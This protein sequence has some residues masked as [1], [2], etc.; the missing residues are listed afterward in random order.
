MPEEPVLVVGAGVAGLAAAV[1]LA[2]RGRA[3]TV[4]ER[5]PTPGGKL[6]EVE[7]DGRR[8]DA[9][10]TVLTLRGIFDELFDVAG[11]RL[12]EHLSLTPVSVLAR[13]AWG[14]DAQL[15]LHADPVRSADA[16][17]AFAG[18]AEARRYTEFLARSRRVYETLEPSFIRAP[19]P[20][21]A[22]LVR[23]AG[24]RNLGALAA[25]SPFRSLWSALGDHFHDP[26]LR[27][28]FGRYATYLGSSPYQA[29]A[30]LMLLAHVEQA[31]V[32]LVD[33]GMHRIAQVLA[34]LATKLGATI[35]YES[36]AR[37]I[38]IVR[39]E[40]RGVILAS[41]ERVGASAV[42]VNADASAL[43]DGSLGVIAAHA[44]PV[45][46]VGE[47]SLSA[48]TW[49]IVAD[50]EG[51]AL[52][53]HTVFFSSDYAR[54]FDDIFRRDSLPNEPTVYICA[55]DRDDVGRRSGTGP[56]RLLCL[57]NA[58]PTGDRR[59]FTSAEIESCEQR[60]F[61]LL[62]RSGL[63]IRRTPGRTA[64]TTPADF[65]RLFPG[66]GGSLYG[67]ASHGWQASFR[68]PGVRTRTRG[69]YLAGGS[70][71]PGPGVPMAA[72]CGRLAAGALIAD[73]ASTRR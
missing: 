30:T 38:E 51:F 70:I 43:G 48:L 54:E 63:R 2:A 3:V 45:V 49:N 66:S 60:T 4:L 40:T 73:S 61:T 7:I 46:P 68:R 21:I 20:S 1:E 69:L 8:L 9:G 23:H 29:P 33:G 18:A 58:P 28:L 27:Q 42:I 6:R 72:L 25:V 55:Q 44:A 47:R 59:P 10:P 56:E 71:H 57:V 22:R 12:E 67:R 64:I 39:G 31:G 52:S 62:E 13:H 32:W 37:T 17:G 35:R 41:G 36:E 26:R 11:T 34:Q 16:I 5:G 14:P 19:A 50:A 15:D 65:S 53:R 24:L